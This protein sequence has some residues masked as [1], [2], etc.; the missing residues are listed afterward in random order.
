MPSITVVVPT[1]RRPALLL[2]CVDGILGGRF[3]DFEVVIVDQSEDDRTRAAVAERYGAEPR[4]RFFHSDVTGA[5][6]ARNL[7]A[8]KANGE[9]IVCIDD[10]AVPL[11]GWLEAYAA[12]FREIQPTPGMVGGRL[13]LI[14]EAPRP[15]WL[16]TDCLA[17]LGQYDAG[18][19]VRKF[20]AGDFP[21]SGNF[22]LTKA[23]FQR[24]GGFDPSLGF[25]RERKHPLISGEDSYLAL[26]VISAGQP[27]YYHPGAEVGHLVTAGK[28]RFGY[29]LSRFYWHGRSFQ[30]LRERKGGETRSWW[31]IWQDSKAKRQAP[32]STQSSGEPPTA[33]AVK[34]AAWGAFAAGVAAEKVASIGGTGRRRS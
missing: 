28:L 23:M 7:G 8:S 31:R 3:Q 10:D 17:L 15:A 25:D 19:Q 12:A 6:R 27:I 18:E 26:Q 20:P 5:S 30:K 4:V 22:A 16:P 1:I 14:W 32:G 34:L 24:I 9:F 11:P 2:K 33:T 13:R 21:M 29:L